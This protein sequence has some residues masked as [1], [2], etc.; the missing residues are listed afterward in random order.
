LESL[1]NEVGLQVRRAYLDFN[2]AQQ[3]LTAAEAQLR[4]ADLALQ[5]AEE[6]YAAGAS[7]LVELTQSRAARVEAAS[8]LVR[9]RYNL[10]FERILVDYYVGDLDPARFLAE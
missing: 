2:A 5:A 9:A 3:Q 8:A 6:R 7:T 4:A 10:R 1:L